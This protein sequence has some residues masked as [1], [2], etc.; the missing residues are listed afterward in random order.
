M[1]VCRFMFEFLKTEW[2]VYHDVVRALDSILRP[3]STLFGGVSVVYVLAAPT[4]LLGLAP[5]G[6]VLT[7]FLLIP[8]SD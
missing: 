2:A 8:V 1:R 7:Q 4:G 6:T 5:R 3:A